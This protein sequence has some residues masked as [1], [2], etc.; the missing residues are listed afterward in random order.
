[1]QNS[2]PGIVVVEPRPR[3][4]PELQRQ[5]LGEDVRVRQ[6]VTF[7]SLRKLASDYAVVVLDL[8][9]APAEVLQFLGQQVGRQRRF[10]AITL[11]SAR[12]AEL[13]WT[14]RDLGAVDFLVDIPTGERLAYLCRRQWT[15]DGR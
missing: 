7:A 3:W 9:H 13:E 5:F 1:M 8:D 6:C 10:N 15:V 11:A 2:Q 4:T 14:T 12:T